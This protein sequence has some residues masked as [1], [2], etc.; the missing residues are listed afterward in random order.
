MF[1]V[2]SIF[3]SMSFLFQIL[4]KSEDE[5]IGVNVIHVFERKAAGAKERALKA[6]KFI[7]NRRNPI[8]TRK[9]R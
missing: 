3:T 8:R 5:K 1:R 2:E 6:V 4:V 7:V 9:R